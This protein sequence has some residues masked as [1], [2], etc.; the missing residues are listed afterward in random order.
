ML[1]S[2][3]VMTYQV[4][5]L[6]AL[7]S[8]LAGKSQRRLGGVDSGPSMKSLAFATVYIRGTIADHMSCYTT[9]P[10]ASWPLTIDLTTLPAYFESGS[11]Q[12]TW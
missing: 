12:D 10:T 4:D 5:F 8:K 7:V 11:L 1:T 9:S 3:H 6:M 2:A